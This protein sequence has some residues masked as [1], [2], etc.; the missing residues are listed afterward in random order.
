MTRNP[1]GDRASTS[2]AAVRVISTLCRV[3]SRGRRAAAVAI[4]PLLW[5]PAL[6]D[7]QGAGSTGFEVMQMPAGGR[8]AALAGAYSAWGEDAD[9]VFFNPAGLAV[10]ERAASLSYQRHV[11]DISLGSLAGAVRF[12]P[13]TLGAG[14]AFLDGGEVPEIV[15]DDRFGGQRGR[16]TGATVSA[17]ESAARLAVAAP[18]LEGR[19]H[20]GAAAGLA[21]SELAGISR[22]APILDLG[23]RME[24]A[25]ALHLALAFRNLGGSARGDGANAIALPSEARLGAGWGWRGD[26]ELGVNLSSDLAYR[27]R[28][29]SAALL[30][31]LE[32]GL[33]PSEPDAIGAVARVGYVGDRYLHAWSALQLGAGVSVGR[34]SIDYAYQDLE[35]FGAAHRFGLRWSGAAGTR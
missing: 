3:V 31:G 12:G 29:E 28:E 22:S 1:G 27:I 15:P 9:V 11:M 4:L 7:G 34:I 14:L 18:L 8:A 32:G 16:A 19:V 26:N 6:L 25:P 33:L 17:R 21:M 2:S 20:L 30:L 35:Y 10:Q 5:A 23:G 13:V 24:V